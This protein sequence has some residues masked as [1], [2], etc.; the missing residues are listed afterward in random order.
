MGKRVRYNLQKLHEAKDCLA[1]QRTLDS[2]ARRRHR[3]NDDGLLSPFLIDIGRIITSPAM[4]RMQDKT[5][6]MPRE[7]TFGGPINRHTHSAAVAQ[8]AKI[9]ADHL[10]LNANLCA[11]SGFAHDLGH[12]PFG[13]VGEDYLRKRI[14]VKIS[15][16]VI[17]CIVLQQVENGGRGHNL[18]HQTLEAIYK[19]SRAN[20]PLFCDAKTPEASV[21]MFVDKIAYTFCD[22]ANFVDAGIVTDANLANDIAKMTR[23]FGET[24]IKQVSTCLSALCIESASKNEVSFECSTVAKKF[25]TLQQYLY[26]RVYYALNREALINPLIEKICERF[27]RL[28]P[29]CELVILATLLTDTDAHRLAKTQTDSEF[30]DMINRMPLANYIPTLRGKK[31]DLTNPDLDW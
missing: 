31:F 20:G 13:H 11:A 3:E 30:L 15:H 29:D 22:A 4:L 9:V 14:G 16:S 23:W 26:K 2:A 18:T 6:V 17:G 27:I 5:Q 21:I 7:F 8:F 1:G 12:F 19:H 10:G 25:L 28:L 24:A